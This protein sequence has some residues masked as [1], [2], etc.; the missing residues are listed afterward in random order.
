MQD[1]PLQVNIGHRA[2]RAS[3]ACPLKKKEKKRSGPPC[4]VG[5]CPCLSS[6]AK[7]LLNTRLG[8]IFFGELILEMEWIF[9][10][11]HIV[12]SLFDVCPFWHNIIIF[13]YYIIQISIVNSCIIMKSRYIASILGVHP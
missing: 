13:Q 4:P 5:P 3:G 7:A 10:F 1:R 8:S 11:K 12:Q 9:I 2:G 6:K